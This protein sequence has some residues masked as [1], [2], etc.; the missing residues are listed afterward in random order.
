MQA[1]KIKRIIY[2]CLAQLPEEQLQKKSNAQWEQIKQAVNYYTTLYCDWKVDREQVFWFFLNQLKWQF[3]MF[4]S[5]EQICTYFCTSLS[6][7]GSGISRVWPE[8]DT[9]EFFYPLLFW[10]SWVISL[11]RI[12]IPRCH[13]LTFSALPF[14]RMSFL[15]R[16]TTCLVSFTDVSRLAPASISSALSADRAVCQ[17]R[18]SALRVCC[19]KHYSHPSLRVQT[20][21][22]MTHKGYNM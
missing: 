8:K 11:W 15:H 16:E 9:T 10:A 12:L 13:V 17:C 6:A 22:I 18:G 5:F 1:K 14:I 19:S 2:L 21:T 4:S 7:T 3:I 20:C